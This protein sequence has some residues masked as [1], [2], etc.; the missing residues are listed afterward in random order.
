MDG[1]RIAM[2]LLQ[3]VSRNGIS[4]ATERAVYLTGFVLLMSLLVIVTVADIGRLAA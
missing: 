3:A 4:P 1:G 2:A